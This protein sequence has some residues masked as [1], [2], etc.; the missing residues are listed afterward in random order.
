MG[1]QSY[2]VALLAPAQRELEEI[3]AVHVQ[4]VGAGSAR[5]MTDQL[6]HSM[7][8]LAQFPLSG[9]LINDKELR[10]EGYRLVIS[11]DYLCIYRLMGETV[12]IYHIVHGAT[13]YPKLMK[14]HQPH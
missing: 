12:Y 2:E 10:R 6:Y 7:E 4:L 11:G 9:A 8:R 5:R 13:D 1:K 14:E 3:A